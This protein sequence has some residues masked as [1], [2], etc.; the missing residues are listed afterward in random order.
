[1]VGAE[2]AKQIVLG[3]GY[4]VVSDMRLPNDK[5]S[6]MRLVTGQVVMVYDTGTVVV[7]GRDPKPVEVLFSGMGK[8]TFKR[9][10]ANPASLNSMDSFVF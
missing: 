7:Q 9:G 8:A 5:G 3:A 2:I 10:A 6:Q 1:M 4:C